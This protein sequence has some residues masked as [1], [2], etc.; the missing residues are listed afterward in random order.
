MQGLPPRRIPRVVSLG[1]LLIFLGVA[2]AV[3][4]MW[5]LQPAAAH[6]R[7]AHRAAPLSSQAERLPALLWSDVVAPQRFATTVP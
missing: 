4:S 7:A 1:L 5:R 3:V 6:G 2:L